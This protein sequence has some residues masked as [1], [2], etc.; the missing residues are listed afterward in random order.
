MSKDPARQGELI[1]GR[2]PVLECLRAKRRAAKKLFLLRSG[3]GLDELRAA[4]KGVPVVE[5]TRDELDRVSGEQMHQ[6]V[7]LQA[8]P[9]PLIDLT[10]WIERLNDPSA[11]CAVLDEIEDPHNFGAIV[12]S[13]AALGAGAVVF[14]K[15]RA[16]PLSPAALKAA[17]GAMEYVP[18]IQ[19]TNIARALETLKQ[20]NFWCAA[21][22][23]DAE[24]DLWHADLKGRNA[25]VIG[26]EGEG[27]RRLV[28][29]TCDYALRIPIGGPISS[30][31]AS[32]SAALAL[33]EC[34]RQR[35]SK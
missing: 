33:A 22:D 12:R 35:S 2:I 34:A 27:L 19:V 26:N 28:R 5:A 20:A 1:T 10:V 17:A 6:G 7:V 16:A 24:K 13:A 31:N 8:A 29:E 14:G 18:L 9:L 11:F 21:L 30:L 23:A 32:V 25:I 3:K 15:D 4:A